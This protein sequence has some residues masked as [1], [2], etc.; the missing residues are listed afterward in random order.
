[1]FE[2]AARSP[3][4]PLVLK[5]PSPLFRSVSMSR[6]L[7]VFGFAMLGLAMIATTGAT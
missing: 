7:R 3:Y 4:I 2:V 5:F 6:M 1:M